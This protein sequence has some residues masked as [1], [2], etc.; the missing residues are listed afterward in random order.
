[1]L[2][3]LTPDQED[4]VVEWLKSNDCLFNKKLNAYKNTADELQ[5]ETAIL[6]TWVD[7]MRTRFGKIIK[8]SSGFMVQYSEKDQWILNRFDFVRE[9]VMRIKGGKLM[10]MNLLTTASILWSGSL[11]PSTSTS[12]K[13]GKSFS[14]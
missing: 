2:L 3:I 4:S 10:I 14:I 5:I 7:N 8:T 12:S 9:H 6:K 1:M 13:A 11:Q